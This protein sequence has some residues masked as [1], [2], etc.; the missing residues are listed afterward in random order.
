MGTDSNPTHLDIVYEGPALA[1]GSMNVRHLAPTM[2]AIGAL[3]E[4]ANNIVNGPRATVH[5]KVR[6]TSSGSFHIL[7]EVVQASQT[8]DVDF[9]T[10]AVGLKELI[11]GGITATASL[12]GVIKWTRRRKPKLNK[13]NESLFSLELDG[14]H[15]EVPVDL[16]RLYQD[17]SIRRS[18]SELVR[19][20]TE[21]GI[22]RLQI[23]DNNHLLQEV[24]KDNVEDFEAPGMQELLIDQ[25]SRQAF[26]IT[27]LSFKEDNK[28]R[29]TDG[30]NTFSVSMKDAAFQ[31]RVDSN[32]VAF[33]KG[34]VLLCDL[35]TVQWQVQ[36]GVRTEYEVVQ[37]I[38][39]RRAR[40]LP[41]F[42]DGDG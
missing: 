16:L 37:V 30:Q 8:F 22:D 38:S 2:L 42:Q 36:D 12:I 27:S 24:T 9:L 40:Q 29:L 31:K 39:H 17:A 5:I 26:S 4:G 28:W 33:A 34:D 23:W 13:I 15:Y 3:F 19:P 11:T 6:A 25:V 32:Q 10:T 18:V 14:E 7:Y 1:D 20:V 21:Q 35:H 41:L